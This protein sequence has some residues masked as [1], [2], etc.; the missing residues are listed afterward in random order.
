[1]EKTEIKIETDGGPWADHNMPCPVCWEN[2]AVY[3]TNTGRFDV[4]WK[5]Q[6]EGW[7]VCRTILSGRLVIEAA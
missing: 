3:H 6:K 5:C 2:K 1:M 4:C 7:H